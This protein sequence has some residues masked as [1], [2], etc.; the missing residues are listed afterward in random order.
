M[1]RNAMVGAQA[2]YVKRGHVENC[3]APL[4]NAI[5]ARV[6]L[7]R[8]RSLQ[9]T[10]FLSTWRED[11]EER[12]VELRKLGADWAKMS[13]SIPGR[14]AD[15]IERLWRLKLR[16]VGLSPGERLAV[17]VGR[18]WRM[19]AKRRMRL[20]LARAP[21]I[22]RLLLESKLQTGLWRLALFVTL[23]MLF[24]T[25]TRIG[26][27]DSERLAVGSLLEQALD[28]PQFRDLNR[29]EDVRDFL[30]HFSSAIKS[31]RFISF[32][33][34]SI[35]LIY[36]SWTLGWLSESHVLSVC[37]L[38]FSNVRSAA[39]SARYT[40]ANAYQLLGSAVSAFGSMLLYW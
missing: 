21:L 23:F 35:F 24:I 29:L 30:P 32:Q 15:D 33:T 3:G 26:T 17:L 16:W 22:Q 7:L 18:R 9:N 37:W 1:A 2:T 34:Y 12:V 28:L 39:S 40:D 5:D 36:D 31:F 27:A 4:E 25:V 20:T 14:S 38:S 19:M 10:A 11:E 8:E 13:R 6:G